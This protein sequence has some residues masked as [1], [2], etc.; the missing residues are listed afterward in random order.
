VLK[1]GGGEIPHNKPAGEG[2]VAAHAQQQGAG[3]LVKELV[4]EK[5]HR[6]GEKTHFPCEL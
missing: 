5:P 2:G 3:K 4:G 6:R 1:K